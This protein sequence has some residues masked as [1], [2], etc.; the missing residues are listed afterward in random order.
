MENQETVKRLN[1]LPRGRCFKCKKFRNDSNPLAQCDCCGKKF[2][3]D[4]IHG[5]HYSK[6]IK[7]NEELKDVCDKCLEGGF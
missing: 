1:S 2:C 7:P 4:H 6:G 3:F 5:G